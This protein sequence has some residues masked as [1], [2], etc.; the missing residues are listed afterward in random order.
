MRMKFVWLAVIYAV[1]I[2]FA[3]SQSPM[4]FEFGAGKTSRGHKLV[5][6]TDIYNKEKGYGFEP[7]ANVTCSARGGKTDAGFCSAD[8]PFSFSV[9]VPEGNY[10]VTITFGDKSAPSVTTVKA[11]LRRLMLEKV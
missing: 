11:E 10:K 3:H 7:G 8:K 4:K 6:S 1:A 5:Q 2:T 9:A